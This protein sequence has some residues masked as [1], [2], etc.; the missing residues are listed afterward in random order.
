M[1]DRVGRRRVWVS[2]ISVALL[3]GCSGDNP[4]KPKPLSGP[5]LSA[6]STPQDVLKYLEYTYSRRDSVG[7]KS[8]YDPSYIGVSTNLTAPP[9]SQILNFSYADEVAHVA[10]MARSHSI[11]TVTLSFG[12]LTRL[13]SDDPSHPDWATI[14]ISG[15]NMRLEIDAL[16]DSSSAALNPVGITEAFSFKPTAP[17][18]TSPTDTTWKIARWSEIYAGGS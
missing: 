17:D 3:A 5:P 14:Q 18:S 16:A 10:A 1:N 11:T 15:S 4:T 7:T 8:I 12:T 6:R 2:L 13:E 9:V